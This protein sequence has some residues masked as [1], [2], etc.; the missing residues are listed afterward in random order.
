M[1]LCWVHDIKVGVS[2]VMLVEGFF[3]S[4][5]KPKIG[6]DFFVGVGNWFFQMSKKCMEVIYSSY[7]LALVN[8]IVPRDTVVTF[9]RSGMAT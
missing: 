2:N 5:H 8:L 4:R 1:L 3:I 7:L 9:R 6:I